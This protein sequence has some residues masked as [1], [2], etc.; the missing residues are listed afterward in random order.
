M[1]PNVS[2]FGRGQLLQRAFDLCVMKAQVIVGAAMTYQYVRA[3]FELD[4]K[5]MLMHLRTARTFFLVLATGFWLNQAIGAQWVA[6][7]I[8]G[9]GYVSGDIEYG[10]EIDKRSDFD[11]VMSRSHSVLLSAHQGESCILTQ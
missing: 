10:E 1:A 11:D 9:Q 7:L 5:A 6:V 8:L 3:I 4:D 2:M